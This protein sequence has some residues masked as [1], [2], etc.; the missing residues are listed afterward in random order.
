MG[1]VDKRNITLTPEVAKEIEG[2]VKAGEYA[3]DDEAINDALREWKERRDNHGYTI[4]ELRRLVQ[5]GI[6]S[7]PGRFTS[8]EEIKA[9][10]RKRLEQQ[11]RRAS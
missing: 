6:D 11:R 8:I 5:E 4:A 2:A 9:E 3:S 7:G 1:H 10:A